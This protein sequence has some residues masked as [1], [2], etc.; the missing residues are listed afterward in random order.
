MFFSHRNLP[1]LD[2]TSLAAKRNCMAQTNRQDRLRDRVR[3]H[4]ATVTW[5]TVLDSAFVRKL[6]FGVLCGKGLPGII[7]N[8]NTREPRARSSDTKHNNPRDWIISFTPASVVRSMKLETFAVFFDGFSVR[9]RLSPPLWWLV[10]EVSTKGLLVAD[11]GEICV[12]LSSW[13]DRSMVVLVW[14]EPELLLD[15]LELL[16]LLTFN[17][18]FWGNWGGRVDFVEVSMGVNLPGREFWGNTCWRWD[19]ALV[20]TGVIL[21]EVLKFWR[22]V[23]LT[24]RLLLLTPVLPYKS[25]IVPAFY[26]TCPSFLIFNLRSE[27]CD[28]ELRMAWDLWSGVTYGMR[29]V[30]RGYTWHEICDQR[31]HKAWELWSGGSHGM[32]FVIRSYRWHYF[33]CMRFSRAFVRDFLSLTGALSEHWANWSKVT[34]VKGCVILSHLKIGHQLLKNTMQQLFWKLKRCV[35]SDI[36]SILNGYH[37]A[38]VRDA[39]FSAT[40][41]PVT[42]LLTQSIWI[43]NLAP[44]ITIYSPGLQMVAL[45]WP[46]DVRCPPI[47]GPKEA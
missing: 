32:R 25:S 22:W 4:M 11:I 17:S 42:P 31:L 26:T 38:P 44:H 10:V 37:A 45:K 7:F 23:L 41:G 30:I 27:I 18:P 24:S 12:L 36:H 19:F 14:L 43:E 20:S 34:G 21:P 15:N 39:V 46:R 16:W 6:S 29:F 35:L 8:R 47:S 33:S 1:W 40:N 3:A 28:Q 9:V 2:L 5:Y 13:W